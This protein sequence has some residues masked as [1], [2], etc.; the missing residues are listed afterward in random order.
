MIHHITIDKNKIVKVVEIIDVYSFRIDKELKELYIII[1]QL[2]ER[3]SILEARLNK[4]IY[5][6]KSF[7]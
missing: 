4:D 6:L 2:Q 1:Q 7:I 3:I 5:S